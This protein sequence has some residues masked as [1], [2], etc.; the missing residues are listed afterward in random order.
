[1]TLADL[2]F[3][4]RVALTVAVVLA[5][6]LLLAIIGYLTGRWSDAEN[7]ALAAEES[8]IVQLEPCMDET[9]RE[10]IRVIMFDAV[11]DA[12]HDHIKNLYAVMM[13]DYGAPSASRAKVGMTQGV[14]A[15]QAARIAITKWSPPECA[16]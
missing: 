4:H 15:H 14:K 11:D 3:G 6:M 13:K 9:S 8:H 2:S 10:A 16:N 12:L 7:Y 5:V 1:M